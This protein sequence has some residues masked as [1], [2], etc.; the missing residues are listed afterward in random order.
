MLIGLMRAVLG[1]VGDL[2]EAKTFRPS[3]LQVEAKQLVATHHVHLGYLT[4]DLLD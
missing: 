2:D 1:S 4:S 3:E